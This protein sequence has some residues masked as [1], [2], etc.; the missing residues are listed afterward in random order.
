MLGS[1]KLAETFGG[2]PTVWGLGA[3]ISHNHITATLIIG[4]LPG[5][6][7]LFMFFRAIL[8]AHAT[9]RP[10]SVL[11]LAVSVT[12]LITPYTWTYDQLLLVLPLS[13][14]I[15]AMDR[16]GAPF[17]LTAS[18]FPGD[19]YAC[20]CFAISGCYD[21]G[22]DMERADPSGGFLPVLVGIG[23]ARLV[24][25]QLKMIRQS[26]SFWSLLRAGRCFRLSRAPLRRNS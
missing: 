8:H 15:L 23:H 19:R 24:T 13:A 18:V 16:R 20:R 26:P 10:L 1:N 21:A 14:V 9:L 12:L 11:A 17:P 22:G 25:K 7:I 4:G 6:A 3:L 5:L 2:S